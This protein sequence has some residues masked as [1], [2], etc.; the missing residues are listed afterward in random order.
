MKWLSNLFRDTKPEPKREVLDFKGLH[1]QS[2]A[3]AR[4]LRALINTK[5]GFINSLGVR[6]KK[7][8]LP[9]IARLQERLAEEEYYEKYY[10]YH[11]RR[12]QQAS[13]S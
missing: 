6:E 1:L 10:A 12:I 11:A 8:R 3:N 2:A 9:E 5:N 13:S 4:Y 7:K